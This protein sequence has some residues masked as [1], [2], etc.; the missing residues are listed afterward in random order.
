MLK[1]HIY[2]SYI[3]LIL[4]AFFGVIYAMQLLGIAIDIIRP[5]ITRS[6]HISLMLYGFIP[7]ML[8]ILPF[9]LFDKDKVL[10]LESLAFL[11]KYFIVWYVFLIFMILALLAGNSRSL[12][13]YD[14]PY[15]LNGILAFAGLFYILAILK[16]INIYTVKPLWVKV[17]FFL[18]VVSPF[19]LLFLMNPRYGQVEKTLIGPHGDNT[20]GMSFALVAI[21]YL[22]IKLASNMKNFQTKWHALW[23]IPLVFYFIS[24]FY[25]SFIGELSYNAEWFFQYL[26]LLYIPL[27]YRWWKD[28][29]LSLKT[30]ATLFASIGAF[31]LV[32]IEGNIIFIPQLRALFHRNDLI[33]GHAHIAMGIGVLF[34]ALSIIE[35]YVK[36]SKAVR[37]GLLVLLTLMAIVL[38]ISGFSQASF[39]FWST[40]EMWQWRAAFG[41]MILGL[42]L[43]WSPYFEKARLIDAFN[44]L[45]PI[46]LYHLIAFASDGIG[47]LIL[48]FFGEW[49]FCILG[50]HFY[51]YY[52]YIVFGFVSAVGIAH[53]MGYIYEEYAHSLALSTSIIRIVVAGGFFSLY[54]ANIL[55]WIALAVAIVDLGLALIY[56]LGIKQLLK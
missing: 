50:Q 49:L 37:Y 31:L 55:G 19:I 36:F 3:F 13:F 39:M 11:E 12:P 29:G 52:Q 53:I 47:G 41:V 43:F 7:L 8:S 20:L 26:T 23:I 1:K 42:L 21:Y 6:L 40:Q 2:I 9:A 10:T 51:G 24:V 46:K 17:S 16:S 28:A 38:S 34:L 27:F 32:D 33:I 18:V 14:F 30:N 56:L 5:D 15:A 25:R 45:T 48:L 54:Q 35:S 22:A 4:A 44:T